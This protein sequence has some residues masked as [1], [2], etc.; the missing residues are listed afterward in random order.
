MTVEIFAVERTIACLP[1]L[2]RFS[3]LLDPNPVAALF[4]GQ[5]SSAF[6]GLAET[7]ATLCPFLL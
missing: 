7:R 4:T 5:T 2:I 3:Q 6:F 1:S